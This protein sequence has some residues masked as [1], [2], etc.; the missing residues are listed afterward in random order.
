ML[1]FLLQYILD[2]SVIDDTSNMKYVHGCP[3]TLDSV[4]VF[5]AWEC[6]PWFMEMS[7]DLQN[8]ENE[9]GLKINL[10]VS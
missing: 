10:D 1:P 4:C 2:L 9:N 6:N 8:N 7:N 5:V 3:F